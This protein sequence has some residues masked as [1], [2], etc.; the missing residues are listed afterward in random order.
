MSLYVYTLRAETRK[1][2]FENCSVNTVNLMKYAGK[3]SMDTSKAENAA[4]RYWDG[5]EY[6]DY[7]VVG[8]KFATGAMV[9]KSNKSRDLYSVY[10][11]DYAESKLAGVLVK[12]NNR[13]KVLENV[14]RVESELVTVDGEL[15]ELVIYKHNS[16]YVM[17][18][19]K[20]VY[21]LSIAETSDDRLAAH[22]VGYIE[23]SKT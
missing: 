6:P 17:V 15:E 12:V 18:G 21:S 5:K 22:W 13:F 1:V 8:D 11:D 20:G 3:L 2:L 10:D 19:G 7:F 23:N 4:E 9:L 16:D 14:K